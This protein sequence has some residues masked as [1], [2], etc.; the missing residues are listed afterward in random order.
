MIDIKKIIPMKIHIEKLIYIIIWRKNYD[1][2]KYEQERKDDIEKSR[3]R[4]LE[5][6]YLLD[7]AMWVEKG[8][9][10][11]AIRGNID[12]YTNWNLW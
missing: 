1:N 3:K 8:T 11:K 5:T 4:M 12:L 9:S 2:K 6:S 10:Y 7:E